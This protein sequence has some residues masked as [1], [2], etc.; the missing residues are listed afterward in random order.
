MA[1]RSQRWRQTAA[2]DQFLKALLGDAPVVRQFGRDSD[3]TFA[4]QRD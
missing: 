3:E 2:V 4:G 1:L